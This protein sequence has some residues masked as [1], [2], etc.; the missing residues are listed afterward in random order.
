MTAP[1]LRATG[2][3]VGYGRTVIVRDT[4]VELRAGDEIALLGRSGAGKTTLL[5]ALAGLLPVRTGAVTYDDASNREDLVAMVFQAPSL[6][7]ELTALEN[8]ALPLRLRG[9][10]AATAYS[11]AEAALGQL[12]VHG[13]DAMPHELSG[14]QQQRVAV[15]R[16]LATGH[17][18]VLADEP[19]GPLDRATGHAVLDALRRHVAEVDGA[20]VVAS[21]DTELVAGFPAQWTMSDS[22]VSAGVHA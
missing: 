6:V 18:V 13:V 11:R 17:R 5:L 10:P 12:A 8:V 3:T 21:H 19:T 14:G 16:V 22:T 2:V 9:T 15:A 20:L 7:P 4:S 1:L